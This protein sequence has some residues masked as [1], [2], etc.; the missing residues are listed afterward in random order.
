MW[1]RSNL[2]VGK[3]QPLWIRVWPII[4]EALALISAPSIPIRPR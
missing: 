2:K 1:T 3:W 4:G